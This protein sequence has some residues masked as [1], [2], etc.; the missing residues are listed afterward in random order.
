MVDLDGKFAYSPVMRVRCEGAKPIITLLPNPVKNRLTVGGI[1]P[2]DQIKIY[3]IKGAFM[4]RV[5][6]AGNVEEIDISALASGS[7]TAEIIRKDKRV[8]SQVFIKI[9]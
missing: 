5:V 6:T 2:G 3:S 4:K 9:Q 7:Y 1:E 8:H